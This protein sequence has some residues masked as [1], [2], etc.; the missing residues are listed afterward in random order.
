MKLCLESTNLRSVEG[1]SVAASC[2]ATALV[3]FMHS[4]AKRLISTAKKLR[5]IHK[6]SKTKRST[7]K[8]TSVILKK[9]YLRD[10]SVEMEV[11]KPL[12]SNLQLSLLCK[13]YVDLQR[14]RTH[15]IEF[16]IRQ[17]PRKVREMNS[18]T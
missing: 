4:I 14:C 13:F 3:L 16:L 7:S 11:H 1:P 8:H 18:M 5:S 9:T 12:H 10:L 2:A 17:K 15:G 6:P